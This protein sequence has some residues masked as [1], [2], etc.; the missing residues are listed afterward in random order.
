MDCNAEV[1][2]GEMMASTFKFQTQFCKNGLTYLIN[3]FVET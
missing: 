2:D 1:G 3:C